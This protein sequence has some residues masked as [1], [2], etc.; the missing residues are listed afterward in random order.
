MVL[1][2]VVTATGTWAL[3]QRVESPEQAAARAAP[4]PPIPVVA[5]LQSGN[6]YGVVSVATTARRSRSASVVKP[7]AGAEVVTSVERVVGDEVGAGAVLIRANGRPV[8]VLPG[9]FAPYRDLQGGDTGDDVAQLQHGLQAAGHSIGSDQIGT[10][11]WGTKA[12]LDAMYDAAGHSAPE[13]DA[14]SQVARIDA[15]IA[16]GATDPNLARERNRL[17]VQ[18]GSRAVLGEIV[19]VPELPAVVESIAAVGDQIEPSTPFAVVGAG[20]VV[21][22]ATMPTASVANI[23]VGA[24]GVLT[25]V[26]GVERTATVESLSPGES[27]EETLITMSVEVPLEP[28]TAHLVRIDDPRSEGGES[29]LAPGASVVSRDGRSYVYVHDDGVFREVEVEV[30]GS[31][32]GVAA[33]AAV[34]P[35]ARLVPGTEV[36]VGSG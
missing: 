23:E 4:V 2:A 32:G 29:L 20:D 1:V 7:A 14:R 31:S 26:T 5:Q 21:L 15:E 36:R 28:G 30:T 17:L 33:I 16:G 27:P 35:V 24:S 19:V 34:D 3:A 8:F 11:G 25:D 6:L 13:T 12:A 10:F 9:E 18:V 22:T